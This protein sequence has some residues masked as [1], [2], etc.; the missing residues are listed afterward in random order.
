[1]VFT[2]SKA[3]IG[4]LA[5]LLMTAAVVAVKSGEEAINHRTLNMADYA[6]PSG[7]RRQFE[8]ELM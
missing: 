4:E 5:H 7:R 6:G 8:R 1:V 2:R 3:T